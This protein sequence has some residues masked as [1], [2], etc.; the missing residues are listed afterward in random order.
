MW[1]SRRLAV[2]CYL[3][4][5]P[6]ISPLLSAT[7][8]AIVFYPMHARVQRRIRK[9]SLAA[10]VSTL[11]VVLVFVAPAV[12]VFFGVKRELV[13]LYALLDQKSSESGGFSQFLS[14]LLDRPMALIGRYVDVSQID[15]R[16]ELSRLKDLAPSSLPRLDYAGWLVHSQLRHRSVH[17]VLFVSEGPRGP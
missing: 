9:P 3:L 8:I 16:A 5:Q 6:F 13:N 10:L 14:G 11:L 1:F 12:L 4:F 7:V 17:F 2:F 15:A